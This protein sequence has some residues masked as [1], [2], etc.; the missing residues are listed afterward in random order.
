[1]KF[2]KERFFRRDCWPM[3]NSRAVERSPMQK[4]FSCASIFA[5]YVCGASAAC[6]TDIIGSSRQFSATIYQDCGIRSQIE[7]LKLDRKTKDYT[8]HQREFFETEC[9]FTGSK[10]RKMVCHKNGKTILA[11][12]TFKLT[13]DDQPM[14]PDE[15]FGHRYTCI[16]GCTE[17]VPKYLSVSPYEC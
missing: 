17:Q 12:A 6:E 14:C 8:L 2:E 15:K 10:P 5:F 7:I 3:S 1:M 11:G 16:K 4:L 13:Y 9:A